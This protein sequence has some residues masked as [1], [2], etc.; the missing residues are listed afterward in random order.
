MA[1]KIE[2]TAKIQ[3]I[4]NGARYQITVPKKDVDAK[5]IDPKKIHRVIL[6]PIEKAGVS[7]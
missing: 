5:L 4:G 3:I 1:D 2:F 7:E 6:I